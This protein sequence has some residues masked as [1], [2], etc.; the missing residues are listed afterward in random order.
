MSSDP[1]P[2]QMTPCV[3]MIEPGRRKFLKEMLGAGALV[4]SVRW[5]E[6]LLAAGTNPMTSD[7]SATMANA[8]LHPNVYL[9]VDTDGTVYIIAHRSEMGSGSKTALPRIVADELD[10]DWARVKIV[11]APGDEKFGDQD[12]DG[13]HS[14]RSFFDPLQ[15]G[16]ASCRERV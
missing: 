16:R 11:Q 4:L 5:P 8:P 9:A 2:A 7:A 15:I 1:L 13:S 3:K 10:A 6:A 12:T 14:V